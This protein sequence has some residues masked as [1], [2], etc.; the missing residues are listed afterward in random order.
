MKCPSCR[1]DNP[2]DSR[3]CGKC[4]SAIEDAAPTMSYSPAEVETVGTTLR[5]HPGDRFGDRYT[6]IEE[7]G[8]GGMGR[9]YKAEDHDLGITVVLK[10]IRPDLATRPHIL[11]RF[12][13]ETV[14]G[15][16]ISHEN[17]IRI[18][19]LGE[20]NKVKYISMDFIKGE[21]LHEL[22]RS[23]G[24]LSLAT[25]LQIA[26]QV[27]Q[28]LRAAHGKGIVHQDVKPENIMIDSS[29]RV[30]VADFGL[31]RSLAAPGGRSSH[32]FYGTPRY[33][34]PEQA[35]GEDADERSDIYSLGAVLYEM[36]TGALPFKA[37]TVEEFIQ[38]H[39]IERPA[40][41]SRLNP[42]LPP[43]CERIILKCLEK[44]KEDRY[45]TVEELLADLEAQRAHARGGRLGVRLRA[46]Q[47]AALALALTGGLGFALYELFIVPRPRPSGKIPV[48][49][50]YAA[51]NSGDKGLN[52]LY[53]WTIPY[54]LSVDLAQS[55]YLNVL[56]QDR[57]MQIL[58][59]LKHMDEERHLS[60]TLDRIA[61]AANVRYFILPSFTRTGDGFWV[62]FTIRKAKTDEVLGEPD[63]LKAQDAG[64]LVGLV[65][66]LSLKV[67][68]RLS[69]SSAEIAADGKPDLG[70]IATSSPEA[71]SDYIDGEI[72]YVRGDYEAAIRSLETAIQKDPNFAMAYLWIAINS[73]YVGD[74]GRLKANLQKAQALADRAG[75]R[76]RYLI[77]GF[78][79][80]ALDESPLKAIENYRKLLELYP[81][82]EHGLMELASIY[83]N[84]EDW[85]LALEQ[86][87][88]ILS[89]D[90]KN[91]LALENNVF[92][93]TAKGLYERA[94][95]L[96]EGGASLAPDSAFFNRQ[97]PLL[98][99]ILGRYDRA[100]EE[101]DKALARRPG[102]FGLR[103]L[104]A[105]L[106]RL[107]EDWASAR[108]I[109]DELRRRGE[110]SPGSLDLRGRYW[111]VHLLF[112]RGGYAEAQKDIREAIAM[113]QAGRWIGDE[114][115]FRTLLA[116]S[117]LR[118]GRA[119]AAVDVLRPTV[120]L[121][122]EN[123]PTGALAGVLHLLG[124]AELGQGRIGE[125]K[126][127]ADE[128][129]R[130]IERQAFP[131]EMRR[132]HHL[133]GSIALAEG[134]SAEAVR[135]FEQA[136]S[137]LPSQRD[138]LDMNGFYLFGLAEALERSGDAAK[139]LEVYR[140]ILS[141]TTGR[142]RWGDLYVRSCYRLGRLYQGGGRPAEAAD[143]YRNFLRLWKDADAGLPEV[144]AARKQ[145]EALK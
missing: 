124:L 60:K 18:H 85:D 17:V 79:S 129:R 80:T 11:E 118:L 7:I 143:H 84:L 103:E 87:N 101:L 28:A 53:R 32:K 72:A 95:G 132:F 114:I 41:P 23:S 130:S 61:E 141:L 110:A 136:V 46:W 123:I 63:I 16:S 22:I 96:C 67:K 94:I 29:G 52:D 137:L 142:L 58:E 139:A 105:H 1:S 119:A 145:L 77:R 24:T 36:T 81:D 25:C 140:Q 42:G 126:Q 99:L 49:V 57:L 127:A 30:L 27:C 131:K 113:A 138:S 15:R 134:R 98:Y 117:E 4:G 104:Q 120:E 135:S 83:R 75:E 82:D 45:Q 20:V 2:S 3:Y 12:K 21:N 76:D 89:F 73:A 116:Y 55:K 43:A 9:I 44:R 38:K 102:D 112:E 71:A 100:S 66:E 107:R 111:L 14:L 33:F 70:Q 97:L 109:F 8:E 50:L 92:I 90:G 86:F 35:R 106:C 122:R 40:P 19:D 65:A 133:A 37:D 74:Y 56:P 62:S 26:I 93:Y 69:L 39:T 5:F 51:N 128:L 108:K 64:D 115:D 125:A 88:K 48:A 78:A 91:I 10:M 6:I 68:S 59:D 31:A 13:K 34:S 54:L 121:A 47:K 144:E